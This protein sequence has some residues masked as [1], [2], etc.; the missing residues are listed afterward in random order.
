MLNAAHAMRTDLHEQLGT[1]LT[2]DDPCNKLHVAGGAANMHASTNMQ[3]HKPW[4]F[5][6]KVANGTSSGEGRGTPEAWD[7]FVERVIRDELWFG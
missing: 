2:L 1:D 7:K 5:L 3:S 6:W 4:E